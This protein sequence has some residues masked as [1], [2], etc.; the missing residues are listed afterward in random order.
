M[1]KG[2]DI[3]EIKCAKDKDGSIQGGI[4]FDK[5]SENEHLLIFHHYEM[6]K[7]EGEFVLIQHNKSMF[8]DEKNTKQLI[9]SLLDIFP[10]L[11][12]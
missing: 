5:T 4:S 9:D 7:V 1:Q 12:K 8:L 11:K 6:H 10:N 2:I 3:R